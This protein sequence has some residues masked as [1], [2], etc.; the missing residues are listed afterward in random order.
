MTLRSILQRLCTSVAMVCLPAFA[1]AHIVRIEI[2]QT[3]P[4]FG[5]T[6]LGASGP[7]EVLRGYA[8]GELDPADPHNRG[9]VDIALA[10]RNERGMVEYRTDIV[11]VR[12]VDDSR[13]NR[14]VLIELNNRG[15]VRVLAE[16]N[17]ATGRA[18]FDA[19]ANAGNG[20][21][22]RQGYTI[23]ELGW[24]ATVESGDGRLTIQVPIARNADFT[25]IVGPSLQE[26]VVDS[27][28][29]RSG[30]LTYRAATLSK[31]TAQLTVRH[32]YADQP[33]V[34]PSDRWEYLDDRT[35]GLL[36]RSTPFAQGTLYEFTYQAA[37]PLVAGIGFAAVRDVASHLRNAAGQGP[38][39]AVDRIY[40]F[41]M[42]QPIRFAHDFVR[43]G[44]N[45]DEH[46]ARVF[47]G[48]LNWIGGASGG[49]FNY[50]FAQP[51]R[52][53]RQHIGRWYPEFA[54]P[55]ANQVLTDH[56]TGQTDGR[57]RACMA[58]ATCPKVFEVNSENEVPGPRRC[59]CCTPI[60]TVATFRTRPTRGTI[61]SPAFP[62][63]QPAN[64]PC[65]SSR[66]TR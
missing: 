57:L 6:A 25:P 23:V 58:T 14:R 5:G 26:F 19:P 22:M 55:F 27:S 21:L 46:G 33:R 44:F 38:A 13:A 35:I 16:L 45:A 18:A 15:G 12:P 20:F 34:I 51:G 32:L 43:L 42:S 62:T 66:Q 60:P 61:C 2:E 56:V 30:R 29:V 1:D 63:A 39:R 17:A 50:R 10:P 37:D 36:P 47:D 59:R 48:M 7:Y 8:Y 4:A 54:F 24:D 53:H 49:F 52:T 3:A 9:I 31:D 40:S 64:R 11:I 65:A 28:D 41:G